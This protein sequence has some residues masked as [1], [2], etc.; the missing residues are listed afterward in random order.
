MSLSPNFNVY[1]S[2]IYYGSTHNLSNFFN[3]F[4]RQ[5]KIFHPKDYL[6]NLIKEIFKVS[7]SVKRASLFDGVL[8]A[9]FSDCD[10]SIIWNT[11][12][13]KLF[14][15]KY[16]QPF[17]CKVIS[18]RMH[19]NLLF[20]K[21]EEEYKI[22]YPHVETYKFLVQRNLLS[23]DPMHNTYVTEIVESKINTEKFPAAQSC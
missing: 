8:N 7:D 15:K 20:Q 4:L 14:A 17:S 2:P 3:E 19:G 6:S 18:S 22:S 16:K 11:D 1:G 23:N 21:S 12:A 9:G 10:L 13:V 5:V